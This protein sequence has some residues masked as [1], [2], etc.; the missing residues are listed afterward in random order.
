MREENTMSKVIHV[1]AND[2]SPLGVSMKSL[3][4]QDGRNGVGGSEQYLLTLCDF[5]TK[6]G[7]SVTLYND[8]L[9]GW[10]SPFDQRKLS[11]FNPRD[12]RDILIMF[13]APNSVYQKSNGKRIFLSCDQQT[14]GDFRDFLSYTDRVVTISQFHANYFSKRYGINNV[15]VI[16]IPI[17]L[18]DYVGDVE[19]IPFSCTFNSVPDRGL[20]MLAKAW[21]QI[22]E[23]VPE[24]NLTVTGGWSLW[25]GMDDT[26]SLLP[27]RS[28]FRGMKNVDYRGAVKRSELI[29]I[30]KRSEL[31]TYPC[32]YDELFCISCAEAQVAGA[33][34]ITSNVGALGTTNMGTQIEGMPGVSNWIDQFVETVVFHLQRRDWLK[35]KQAII[36]AKAAE[37]FN[38][39]RIGAQWD[40]VLSS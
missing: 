14:T 18:D 40:N 39:N 25:N 22:V 7:H 20:P 19:K 12:D 34:P 31:F 37:R 17:R 3:Y 27:Y 2:G 24:A 38:I 26:N 15:D 16:D 5:W 8:P 1:R 32:Q 30:Q 6:M 10:E 4:G 9:P 21:P 13:R 36:K 33:Y 35:E 29:Q 11:E 28:L 23:R